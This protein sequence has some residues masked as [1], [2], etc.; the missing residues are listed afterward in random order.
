MAGISPSVHAIRRV[1]FSGVLLVLADILGLDALEAAVVTLVCNRVCES[2][3]ICPTLIRIAEHFVRPVYFFEEALSF[4]I[5]IFVRMIN[6][7]KLRYARLISA[8]VEFFEMPSI[9]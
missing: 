6:N 4:W 3:I 8:A 5:W 1:R 7:G 9:W 2:E